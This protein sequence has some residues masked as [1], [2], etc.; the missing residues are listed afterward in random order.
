MC[1]CFAAFLYLCLQAHC[2]LSASQAS[3][4]LQ[5][6][7]ATLFT[8]H[9]YMALQAQLASFTTMQAQVAFVSCCKPTWL[10]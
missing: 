1:S 5:A 7:V 3:M 8:L 9:A 6:Q 2:C 4:A 10:R